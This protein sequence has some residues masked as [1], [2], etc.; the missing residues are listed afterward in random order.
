MSGPHDAHYLFGKFILLRRIPRGLA[1]GMKAKVE[2]YEAP[3]QSF[4]SSKMIFDFGGQNVVLER[5]RVGY[6]ASKNEALR[7]TD[8][9]QLAAESFIEM[10]ECNRIERRESPKF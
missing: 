8:T 4:V 5:S 3:K 9:L 1:A 2:L 10:M 6:S 7:T